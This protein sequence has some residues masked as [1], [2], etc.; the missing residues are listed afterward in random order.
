LGL[1]LSRLASS[2]RSSGSIR[3]LKRCVKMLYR[4]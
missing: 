1:Y 2:N 4:G 3:L